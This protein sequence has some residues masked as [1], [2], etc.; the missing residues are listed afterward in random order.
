MRFLDVRTD[1]ASKK[2][3]GSEQSKHVLISFLNA[4]IDFGE[5]Q[6]RQQDEE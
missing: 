2:V 6:L 1:F 5:E 3:F 4:L